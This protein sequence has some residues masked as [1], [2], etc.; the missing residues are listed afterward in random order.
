MP[1]YLRKIGIVKAALLTP[2]IYCFYP[3]FLIPLLHLGFRLYYLIHLRAFLLS[4]FGLACINDHP[5]VGCLLVRGCNPGGI[6]VGG[7]PATCS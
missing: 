3:C 1:Q 2:F 5:T 4:S 6:G 7:Y